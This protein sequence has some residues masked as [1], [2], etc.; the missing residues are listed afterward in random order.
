[1]FYDIALTALDAGWW[2]STVLFFSFL[3]ILAIVAFED[4]LSDDDDDRKR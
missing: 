1:M 3:G 4:L 2:I